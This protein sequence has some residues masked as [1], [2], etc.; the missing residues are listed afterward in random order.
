MARKRGCIWYSA[1]PMP[2]YCEPCPVHRKTIWGR[3]I[4]SVT[5][6]SGAVLATRATSTAPLAEVTDGI[7]LP[8]I[9]FLC[10]GQG[11]Q[12]VGMGRALYQ[13][14]PRFRAILDHC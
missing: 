4:P 2:T 6:A 3:T 9:V 13:M 14:H 11:S 8:Q 5:S 1:R 7:V 10:T 12:Y